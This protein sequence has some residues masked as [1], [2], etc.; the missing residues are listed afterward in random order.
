[1]LIALQPIQCALNGSTAS[2]LTINLEEEPAGILLL[3]VRRWQG[4]PPTPTAPPRAQ[5]A[6]NGA[7]ASAKTTSQEGQ[8]AGTWRLHQHKVSLDH[9]L[10]QLRVKRLHQQTRQWLLMTSNNG[11]RLE[12]K[13]QA[14]KNDI[15]L[16]TP[17]EDS[18]QEPRAT[19]IAASLTTSEN[20]QA[21]RYSAPAQ[22]LASYRGPVK[23]PP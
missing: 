18:Y 7:T 13:A 19:G 22:P 23:A 4:A 12:K 10:F 15:F 17:K 1:M 16:Q 21:K 14:D 3:L 20:G 2:V 9:L 5:S 11:D 8:V 6:P